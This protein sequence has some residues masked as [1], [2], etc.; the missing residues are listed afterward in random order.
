M[1][2]STTQLSSTDHGDCFSTV[3]QRSSE[4]DPAGTLRVD[5]PLPPRLRFGTLRNDASIAPIRT[6]TEDVRPHPPAH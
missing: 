2:G 3:A 5:L 4:G 1:I 6:F